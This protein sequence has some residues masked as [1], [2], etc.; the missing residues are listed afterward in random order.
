M[1][2]SID[3]KRISRGRISRQTLKGASICYL[4][5]IFLP[6]RRSTIKDL[7][8]HYRDETDSNWLAGVVGRYFCMANRSLLVDIGLARMTEPNAKPKN[9]RSTTHRPRS[10]QKRKSQKLKNQS[11][12]KPQKKPLLRK[13]PQTRMTK[14]QTTDF[15]KTKTKNAST[16]HRSVFLCPHSMF[17]R[18]VP[19]ISRISS[20][21]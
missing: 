13:V 6:L 11:L 12:K 9:Q 20:L 2:R 7:P 15:Q 21:Q 19:K 16:K 18:F 14:S 10:Q 17:F 1:V 5:G 3:R 8:S 4:A